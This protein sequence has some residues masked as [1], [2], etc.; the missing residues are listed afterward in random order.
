MGC[1]VNLSLPWNAYSDALNGLEN[2]PASLRLLLKPFNIAG[3]PVQ[4]DE[5]LLVGHVL[6]ALYEECSGRGQVDAGTVLEIAADLGV[7][8]SPA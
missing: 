8:S 4:E 6:D 5:F 2:E 7:V 1:P 3:V